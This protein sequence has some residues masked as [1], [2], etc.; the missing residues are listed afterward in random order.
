MSEPANDNIRPLWTFKLND[1]EHF[2]KEFETQDSA[3]F[4]A[5]DLFD[6]QCSDDDL[7]EDEDGYVDLIQFQW[8]DDEMKILSV[9]SDIVSFEYYHGDYAEHNVLNSGPSGVL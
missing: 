9:K 7:Q 5:Q 4:A 2:S 1:E 6:E 8:I 3:Y